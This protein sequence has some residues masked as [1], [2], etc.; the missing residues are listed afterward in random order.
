MARF[1]FILIL[2]LC[3]VQ[4]LYAQESYAVDTN[5]ISDLEIE[6][7]FT[8]IDALMTGEAPNMD[9]IYAFADAYLA[10]NFSMKQIVKTN[11]A[12]DLGE[13][14]KK[15]INRDALLATYQDKNKVLYNS[16]LK[17]RILEITH[18]DNEKTAK[19][20]Y[21]TL[22]KGFIKQQ[23]K[24]GSWYSQEFITLSNC[25]D[26]LKLVDQSIKSFRAECETETIHKEPMK[27]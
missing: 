6:E 12:E 11:R 4:P 15:L 10:E 21:T 14:Q 26:L 25:Y 19:V 2:S 1:I 16:K 7:H 13:P 20:T 17:H 24:D 8:K 5:R 27:L 18:D 3:P 9:D 23:D 22:F